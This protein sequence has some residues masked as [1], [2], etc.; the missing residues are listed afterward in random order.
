ML[1][2][3]LSITTNQRRELERRLHR[4]QQ[5]GEVRIV[6]FILAVLAVAHY[7][8]AEQAAVVLQLSVAQV[9]QYA[10]QF[11]C[12]GGAGVRLKKSPGRPP[13]LTKSEKRQLAHWLEQ[14]P[15][16]CGFNGN[17]WRSPLV[18]QLIQDKFQVT[19]SV[20]YIAELLR[21][22][23]FSYQ[24][25]R[26]V[27]DH[28]D[29]TKR[30]QWRA[31]T[32]PQALWLAREK[33][34]LL[35]FGDEASFPQ[36]GTLSYTWARKGMPPLVKTSG[37]RKGYKVLGL[38]DYFSGRFF[39]M[40]T[41]QRLDSA[42]Y[43]AFL[44][45]VLAQ[46]TQHLVLLQDGARYHTSQALKEFFAVHAARLTVFQLPSYSPDLNP[47]EKLWK[48]IKEQ[49]THLHYFPDFAALTDRVDAALLKFAARPAEILA[50]FG[51]AVHDGIKVR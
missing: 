18:Q 49:D 19:Y 32:W 48:K 41:T 25:A 31:Q 47:I 37:K 4:A 7:Q 34:A 11:L 27:S 15:A 2:F 40:T 10:H 12:Y 16:A 3:R 6:K 23:G 5:L 22:L 44:Q 30:Q 8:T 9:E 38:I 33:K 20:F 45:Q 21:S 14:G 1:R 28:L 29:E 43:T 39:Y 17:C 24:K 51:L 50:L 13:R 42:C 36:W 35:L 26:F 46:T